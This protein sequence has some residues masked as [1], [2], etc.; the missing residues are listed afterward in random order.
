M[1][2]NL[3]KKHG[4]EF[5]L[6]KTGETLKDLPTPWI[7]NAMIKFL[8]QKLKLY[9]GILK[10]K[11]LEDEL[12]FK[13]QKS[14]FEKLRKEY[15]QNYCSNLLE[16]DKDTAKQRRQV[17]KKVARKLQKKKKKNQSTTLE[18]E[19]GIVFDK[20]AVAGKFNTFLSKFG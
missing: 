12:I 20:N 15:K 16:K 6:R 2:K 17:L 7:S 8:K 18:T 19:N 14:L 1:Y 3:F 11:N 5:P 4:K 13:N 10:S 9:I